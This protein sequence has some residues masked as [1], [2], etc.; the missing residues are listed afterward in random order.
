MSMSDLLFVL[1]FLGTLTVVALVGAVAVIAPWTLFRLLSKY[2]RF[3]YSLMGLTFPS[4]SPETELALLDDPT[5]GSPE[6]Q[7][8]WARHKP[9][10]R[11][12]GVLLVLGP[13]AMLIASLVVW[14]RQ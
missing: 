10:F 2:A 9:A 11:A 7:R 5:E 4:N 3:Q 14:A 12:I 8:Y 1:G 13:T 6:A